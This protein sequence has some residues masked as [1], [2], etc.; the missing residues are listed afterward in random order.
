MKIAGLSKNT[1]ATI[2]AQCYGGG[3]AI[4]GTGTNPIIQ[5][6]TIDSNVA[7]TTRHGEGGGISSDDVSMP[8][9]SS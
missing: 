1:A 3:I 4:T 2:N 5:Y 9:N 6:C 8:A 7:G